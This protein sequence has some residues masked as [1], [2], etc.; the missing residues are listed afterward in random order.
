[1]AQTI[2]LNIAG[3]HTYASPLS[4]V[5]KGALSVADDVNISRLN[6]IEPRRGFSYLD[7]EL[8]ITT[9]RT[10]KL[11]FY[12]N[13]LF[14]HYGTTFGLY[15]P[16]GI[17]S[18]GSLTAP[19]NA[20]SVRSKSMNQTLYLTSS[21]GIQKMDDTS[22]S[23]YAAGIPAGL[24]IEQ[25]GSLVT[26]G[27]AI[28]EDYGTVAY[29]YVIARKDAKKNTY[30]GGVS[31]RCIIFNNST[32]DVNVPLKVWLPAG[33]DNTY[34]VQVY[35]SACVAGSTG[36]P[37][38]PNDEL[39]QCYEHPITSTDITNTYFTFTDIQPDDLLGASLYTSPS[40]GQGMLDNNQT[41]PLARDIEEY[42]GYM[43]FADTVS[44]HRF[45]LT[46]IACGGSGLVA[47]DT[48]TISDG[49]TTE[50]YTAKASANVAN[51]EF[52][53]DAASPSIATRID[54]TVRSF[55]SV[56]NQASALLY[57]SLLSSGGSDL[58]GEVLLEERSIGGTAFTVVSSRAIAFSPQLASTPNANQTSNNSEFKNG[59][60]F[61][62][63]ADAESVPA[64]NMFRVGSADDRIKRIVAIQDALF[65]FKENDGVYILSGENQGSF[66]VRA[67]DLS[68]KI[69]APD[70]LAS[71]N[72]YVY[73]LFDAGVAV[74]SEAGLEFI[75]DPIKDKIL[76]LYSS[77]LSDVKA[78]SFG[79][80]YNV[81]GK[82]ILGMPTTSGDTSATQQ[83]VYDVY[84]EK[85][86]RWTMNLLTANINPEDGLLY[87]SP[88][89]SAK[90][91]YERKANDHTDFADLVDYRTII[92][93]MDTS[94]VL[95][96]T[97]DLD[98]GD[99]LQQ[100]DSLAYIESIDHNTSTVV[101]DSTQVWATGSADVEHLRAIHTRIEWNAEFADNP[102]G[103]KL[104]TETNLLFK[105]AFQREATV[106]YF[107]D[108]NQAESSITIDAPGGNGAW[109]EFEFGEVAFGGDSTALPVRLG[110]PREHKRCNLLTVR[111]ETRVAFS[112]YQLNGISLT[113]N[114]VSTR[115]T[116]IQNEA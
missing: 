57:A 51:K 65:I 85:W 58:P 26:S 62:K 64:K 36:V 21:T 63:Q 44:K 55:V 54:N 46:L 29:R 19:S 25:N 112:D 78:Y 2:N 37:G 96:D 81:D 84:G 98:I 87:V 75:S 16:S 106:Y 30:Y 113:F 102:A 6:I 53:V 114:P 18:R 7:Q 48:I 73:G 27:T 92:S 49:T 107:S 39:Q 38:V 89:D 116:R 111:F 103:Q 100:G 71:L 61:S 76:T 99:L 43:F 59:L 45:A 90:I 32:D 60:M 50:V 28:A 20:Q 42:K 101:T 68:A 82:Y 40:Q 8:P 17:L 72:N 88:G 13:E 67:L 41:P 108:I 91:R 4:G 3:L 83:F 95:D 109:G 35:R 31:S 56:L 77:A 10:K 5:P 74:V 80:G 14:V 94:L 47:N 9:D 97:S 24:M 79:V 15:D 12:S 34:Y 23:I 105:Q 86:C 33:L 22:S 1:M 52:A 115:T 93:Y 66:S 104:F 110:I 11:F 69:V 70:S